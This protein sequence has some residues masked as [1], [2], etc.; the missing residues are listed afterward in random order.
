[1]TV[2]LAS[3]DA[4]GVGHHG[5][6]RRTRIIALLRDS[7]EPLSV[8]DVADRVGIHV[9]TARFHL[10]SLVYAS[11]ATRQAETRSGPGR[12]RVVYTSTL[13]D[14]QREQ[15]RG[16]AQLAQILTAAVA[17]TN[18]DASRWLY[19]VGLEWGR[20][21]TP[22]SPPFAAVDETDVS[23]RLV[24][25]L[26]ELSF[27]PQLEPAPD[28]RWRLVLNRCPFAEVARKHPGVPCQLHAGLINGSLAEM[29]SAYR[30][31]ALAPHETHECVGLLGLAPDEVLNS[32]P[33]EAGRADDSG[34]V[35]AD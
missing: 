35:E 6:D 34:P 24:A 32:V 14:P 27:D 13:P 15:P 16:F 23:S 2:S 26:D 25:M 1:M 11:L 21:V 22:K 20:F 33:L 7:R 19:G 18:P 3:L 9:N 31:T 10:E 28:G 29:R 12:P 8:A 5:G 4:E 30:L 17:E